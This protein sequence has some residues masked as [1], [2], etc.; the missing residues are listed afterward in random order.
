MDSS[1]PSGPTQQPSWLIT[2]AASAGGIPA[3]QTVIGAL[4]RDLPA[5]VVILQHRAPDRKNSLLNHILQRGSTLPVVSASDAQAI[6]TGKVYVAR[7]NLHLTVA[8][9][10]RFRYMNGTRIKYLLSSAN[11]L[12][13]S[14]AAVFKDRLIAIV[15]T[16]HGSDGTDGVQTVKAQGG[17]VI[18]QDPASAESKGMPQAAIRSGAVDFVLP[19][20]EI[21]GT[22]DAI[23]RGRLTPL[24]IP[25]N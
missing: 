15:L 25:A 14:A 21:A 19:L 12:F 1:D 22:V 10:R 17:I 13:E 6:E 24:T 2:V 3:L 4:P 18:A 23:V 8:S 5:S 9:D 7:P 11:P 20:E 16:G